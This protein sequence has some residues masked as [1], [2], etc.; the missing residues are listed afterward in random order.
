MHSNRPLSIRFRFMASA[1]LLLLGAPLASGAAE[2]AKKQ[3]VPPEGFEAIFNGKDFT[4]WRMSPK[5]KEMWFI[6]DGVRKSP[7]LLRQWGADL[8]TEKSYRDFA[9]MLD[10]RMPGLSDSGIMFRRL[11]PEIP[12]FGDQE[13]FNLRSKD[14]VGHPESF[15]SEGVGRGQ[16]LDLSVRGVSGRFEVNVSQAVRRVE[17]VRNGELAQLRHQASRALQDTA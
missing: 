3:N 7:G 8:V 1:L 13:Q 9:L 17:E 5:A 4:G 15:G 10:F 2:S 6:E 12:N 11:I 16:S 14:G